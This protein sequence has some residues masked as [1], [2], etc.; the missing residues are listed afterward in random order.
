MQH[1]KETTSEI[2]CTPNLKSWSLVCLDLINN[3]H[4][5]KM[6]N[7][8]SGLTLGHVS[9][10][11]STF[12]FNHCYSNYQWATWNS[13]I[14]CLR[15]DHSQDIT[16]TGDVQET[17]KRISTAC[18]HVI[19]QQWRTQNKGSIDFKWP[20]LITDLKWRNSSFPTLSCVIN[21]SAIQVNTNNVGKSPPA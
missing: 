7:F 21:T 8:P 1:D 4:T 13:F 5:L 20:L 12:T 9:F 11:L 18:D 2:L 16:C 10:P 6:Q 19:K 15:N 17:R 14:S 3:K